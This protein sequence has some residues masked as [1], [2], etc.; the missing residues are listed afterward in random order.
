MTN[1]LERE[2]HFESFSLGISASSEPSPFHPE[3][4]EDSFA[5]DK[6]HG[7]AMVLDGMG[8]RIDGDK[9]SQ[10][11][12]RSFEAVLQNRMERMSAESDLQRAI[13]WASFE[14]A[15][16]FGGTT[17]SAVKF[18]QE[19]G[20]TYSFIAH[21]GDSRV[22]VLR[23]QV[24]VQITDDDSYTPKSI[25]KKISHASRRRN[26]RPAEYAF[27]ERRHQ[28]TQWVGQDRDLN[29]HIYD[30][31]ALEGDRFILTTDGV[32]DNLT[33]GEIRSIAI[34]TNEAYALVAAAKRRSLG[35]SFRAKPDDITAI[36]IEVKTA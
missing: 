32:H 5:Y 27:F 35:R 6:A 18:I 14:T 8:G 19:N 31:T 34:K 21:V 9:A 11:A 29:P 25:T 30:M 26:L 7:F 24:L 12:C 28:I 2:P 33:D 15:Q 4:N 22:Y 3:R 10:V 36:V 16:T 17:L 23:D 1:R 13:A 20:I